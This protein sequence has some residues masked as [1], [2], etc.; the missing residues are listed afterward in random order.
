MDENN[1]YDIEKPLLK[2]N[3]WLIFKNSVLLNLD[4]AD[5]N[6]SI[7]GVC[8]KDKTFDECIKECATHEQ[9]EYG[10]Y[11]NNICLP[12]RDLK[13]NSNPVYRL[14]KKEIYPELKNAVVSTFINKDVYKFPPNQ[15]NNVFF[16]DKFI[17][18]NIDTET[19]LQDLSISSVEFNK[20]KGITVQLVQTPPNLSSEQYIVLKYGDEFA[21]NKPDT[22]FII[23]EE[24]TDSNLEWALGS[25]NIAEYRN[26]YLSPLTPGKKIGD[27]VSYSDIFNIRTKTGILG[28]DSLFLLNKLMIN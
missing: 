26:F 25:F 20:N 19:F 10:Y 15:A 1:F 18:E 5:C 28:V 11:I 7:E 6:D 14:R 16:L 24:D 23:K 9:C 3:K 12:L 22:A 17:L 27:K 4:T 21:F 13:R 2:D 8:Y